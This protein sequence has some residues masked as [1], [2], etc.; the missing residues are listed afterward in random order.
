[1]KLP[2]L[3]HADSILIGQD[4]EVFWAGQNPSTTFD[5]CCGSLTVSHPNFEHFDL[6]LLDMLTCQRDVFTPPNARPAGVRFVKDE[7]AEECQKSTIGRQSQ[8]RS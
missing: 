6:W 3:M 8:L 7:F 5:Q 1:M 2:L 4:L